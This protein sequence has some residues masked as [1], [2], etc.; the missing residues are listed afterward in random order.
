MN[1][2]C[3]IISYARKENVLRLVEEVTNAGIV[4]IYI[5]IDGPRTKEI[6]A[7][8]LE[9]GQLLEK[10]KNQYSCQIQIWQREKNLGSGASVIASLDWAFASEEEVIILEDDLEVRGEFFEFMEFGLQEMKNHSDLKIVTGTNPFPEVTK[11]CFGKLHYPVAWGWA[12]NRT[13]WFELRKLLFNGVPAKRQHLQPKKDLYWKIGKTRALL[14][15]IEAWDVPLASEMYKTTFYTLIPPSNLVS[16]MG[17][18]RHAAHTIEGTWPL[19]LP[20]SDYSAPKD[21]KLDSKLLLDLGK[22][23]EDKIFKIRIHHIISWVLHKTID[24]FRFKRDTTSL[25]DRTKLER[26]PPR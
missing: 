11:G 23:F 7:I 12:T 19:N 24:K 14:G 16:N 26:I 10:K 2:A 9:L 21:Y 3:L 17:F 25:L 13:N 22:D 20:I 15:Q 4:K 18:D 8:Q 6:A 1:L 5:S